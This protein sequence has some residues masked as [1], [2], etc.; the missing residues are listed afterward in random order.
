M[1]PRGFKELSELTLM[2]D[3]MFG[4]VMQ[5]PALAKAVIE[6]ILDV[7]LRRVQY[8]EPQ[9]QMKER[10]EAHAIRLDLYVEDENGSVYNVEVQTTDKRNLPRR[11]RYY[12]SNI[13]LHILSPGVDYR[14]LRKSYVIF[15]CGYDPFGLN[16]CVYTFEN[17]C[18]EVPELPFGDDT[19]KV[20]VNIRG[21]QQG[22]S[23]RLSEMIRYLNGGEVTGETTRALDSAVNDVKNSEERR[24]EYMVMR[25]H[26]MEI[27]EEGREEGM[28][29][30]IQKGIQKGAD[31]F[32]ALV[33]RLIS[34]N[35]L[36]DV[37]RA[38]VDADYRAALYR[39]FGLV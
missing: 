22:V 3:Y 27:R 24:R 35:R 13:D 31:M 23:K 2:D 30:G 37:E 6:C 26:E 14:E 8:V 20:V 36:P 12:Q 19:T 18:L 17:R 7:K 11:M 5:D 21:I 9:K 33:T 16:R 1:E 29:Q 10:Y 15:I 25:L 39:E 28:Q 34:M 38:A 32:G 4:V